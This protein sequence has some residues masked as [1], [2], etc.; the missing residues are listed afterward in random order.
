MSMKKKTM[1]Q[2]TAVLCIVF[3]AGWQGMAADGY[4]SSRSL[5]FGGSA[6][7]YNRNWMRHD[8]TTEDHNRT[9][10]ID[11]FGG[12]FLKDNLLLGI[13]V[14]YT[15][16][17]SE[18]KYV[19]DGLESVYSYKDHSFK[20]GIFL[21]NYFKISRLLRFFIQ[22]EVTAGFGGTEQH[23]SDLGPSHKATSDVFTLD[24]GFV[25]GVAFFVNRG[26][27]IEASVGF[28]GLTYHKYKD[29][30][31]VDGAA[32]DTTELDFGFDVNSLRIQLGI[33][34]YL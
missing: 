28:A 13:K 23:D 29:D 18:D 33:S 1:I 30:N 16:G 8:N 3:L 9:L 25:P 24:I 19:F 34:I 22:T 7:M 20:T 10:E 27:A 32:Y 15:H 21:R 4:T 31:L 26:I 6:G 11:V 5:V 17:R 14:G 12:Y 2:I